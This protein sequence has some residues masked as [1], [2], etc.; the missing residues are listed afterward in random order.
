MAFRD[1]RRTRTG[2][3]PALV[4][5]V[6]ALLAFLTGRRVD[7]STVELEKDT[8][9]SLELFQSS[10]ELVEV[11]AR[12]VAR[13]LRQHVT[14]DELKSYGHE[15]LMMAARRF[16]PSLEV[17]FRA[18]ASYRVRGA[19]ID[20]VRK[21]SALP[22]RLYEKLRMMDAA[23]RYS[24]DSAAEGVQRPPGE[25]PADAQRLLDEHLARMATAMAAGMVRPSAIGEDGELTSVSDTRSPEE[26][27]EYAQLRALL[28]GQ[29]ATLPEDEQELVRRHYFEGER[30]DHVAQD[31]G[32][33][34]SWASRLHTRA[35][36]RLTKRLRQSV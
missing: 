23:N 7:S 28:K 4:E 21:N 15:G 33:S 14:L 6:V 1:W 10:L 12:Q 2:V 11:V 22:R 27:M 25:S 8:P 18:Y 34:K 3:L 5:W 19:M 30:F 32:L 31:L 36:G 29:I 20:G 26:E 16:N 13:G 24:E 9:E 35:I 17:P